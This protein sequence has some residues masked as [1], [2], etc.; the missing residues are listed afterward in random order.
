[1]AI[2]LEEVKKGLL[3]MDM[4]EEDVE[5][6]PEEELERL[7]K[8]LPED[9]TG[10]EFVGVFRD[11]DVGEASE[12]DDEDAFAAA[13]RKSVKK[14][15]DADDEKDD[16]K[17][18]DEGED[19]DG[20]GGEDDDGDGDESDGDLAAQIKAAEKDLGL[21]ISDEEGGDDE[22]DEDA[23]DD[24]GDAD[25]DDDEDDED[26]DEEDDLGKSLTEL[27]DDD[28]EFGDILSA[29]EALR[30][31]LKSFE[32]LQR[33]RDDRLAAVLGKLQKSVGDL[34]ARLTKLL[35]PP[36]EQRRPAGRALPYSVPGSE[37]PTEIDES[38][39]AGLQKS[40]LDLQ[41]AELIEVDEATNML[42]AA[43]GGEEAFAPFRARFDELKKGLTHKKDE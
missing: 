8:A 32:V 29:D 23:E 43:R 15:R 1:M 4:R 5:S 34:D 41:R 9:V 35:E 30:P 28:E 3:A 31:V 7:A 39:P 25:G 16:E 36:D 24:D 20:S 10:E 22:D 17:D 26:E 21:D 13:V 12:G 6:L 27:L 40:I 42:H 11:P 38:S 2:S 18:D 37:K 19:D 33:Q 14:Q